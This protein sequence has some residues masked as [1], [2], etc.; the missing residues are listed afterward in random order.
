MSPNSIVKHISEDD[1]EETLEMRV[2][3]MEARQKRLEA[4]SHIC[5]ILILA[6]LILLYAIYRCVKKPDRQTRNTIRELPMMI[7]L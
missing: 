4:R 7:S 1:T 6:I 2:A 3:K 5:L